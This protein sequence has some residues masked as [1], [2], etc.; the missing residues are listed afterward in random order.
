MPV[1]WHRLRLN[2]QCPM[3]L[4][5]RR[6]DAEGTAARADG[7]ERNGTEQNRTERNG[8]IGKVNAQA[9]LHALALE[10]HNLSQILCAPRC[11]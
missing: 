1:G 7:T 9:L 4:C 11:R 3:P 5:W 6:A 10:A 2:A 8:P